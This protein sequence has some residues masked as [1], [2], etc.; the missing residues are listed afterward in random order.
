MEAPAPAGST[1]PKTATEGSTETKT[2]PTQED[3]SDATKALPPPEF[4]VTLQ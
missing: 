3:G 4:D 2:D 1:K